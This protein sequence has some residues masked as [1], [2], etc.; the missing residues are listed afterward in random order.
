MN[1]TKSRGFDRKRT[2]SVCNGVKVGVALDGELD[3]VGEDDT[4]LVEAR[5][6]AGNLVRVVRVRVLL[7]LGRKLGAKL[8]L[9]D[10]V[11]QR[12]G[13]L[14]LLR[15]GL[16]DVVDEEERHLLAVGLVRHRAIPHVG[17]LGAEGEDV[18]LKVKRDLLV[19]GALGL[20]QQLHRRRAEVTRE[21]R[22]GVVS[23][24]ALAA[25]EK[26]VNDGRHDYTL[27]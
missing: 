27:R 25:R 15:E 9:D 22:V 16:G 17:A 21:A 26:R 6:R 24:N 10:R 14:E 12:R 18:S 1:Q 3:V 19:A 4:E 2:G 13:V 20:A 5:L 7:D 8:G 23:Q 11:A